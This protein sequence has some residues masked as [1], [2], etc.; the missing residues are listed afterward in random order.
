MCNASNI[1]CTLEVHVY[2]AE[3]KMCQIWRTI[4]VYIYLSTAKEN[5]SPW[6]GRTKEYCADVGGLD[7]A[8]GTGSNLPIK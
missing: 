2:S 7:G 6:L 4:L 1:K 8:W 3:E 5:G